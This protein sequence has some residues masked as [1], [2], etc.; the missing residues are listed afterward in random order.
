MELVPQMYTTGNT[1]PNCAP[2]PRKST[3]VPRP[4]FR[5]WAGRSGHY[6]YTEEDGHDFYARSMR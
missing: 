6:I 4:S 1:L 3:I 2:V 5:V